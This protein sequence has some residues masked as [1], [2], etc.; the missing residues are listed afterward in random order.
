MTVCTI[1]LIDKNANAL[2]KKLVRFR[3]G[4]VRSIEKIINLKNSCSRFIV[5]KPQRIRNSIL[6]NKKIST[7]G[8]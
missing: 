3:I 5:L 6:N 4:Y 8:L 7:I 1:L 2:T